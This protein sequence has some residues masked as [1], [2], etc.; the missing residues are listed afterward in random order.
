MAMANREINEV[1]I[2]GVTMI[3]TREDT[4]T[5]ETLLKGV[6]AHDASGEQIVGELD[7]VGQDDAYL[8][9]DEEGELADNDYLP[10]YDSSE[11]KKK[12]SLFSHLVDKLKSIFVTIS[13]N[14]VIEGQELSL[15]TE[16][17]ASKSDNGVEDIY[18]ATLSNILD[19][20]GRIIN[21]MG[22]EVTSDGKIETGWI[23][24][25][26]NTD[27]Q[28]IGLKGISFSMDKQGNLEYTIADEDAFREAIKT[29]DQIGT[30]IPNNSDLDNYK[31]AGTYAV[32]SDESAQT[33]SHIPVNVSGK[34]IVSNNG[35][36]GYTQFYVQNHEAKIFTRSFWNNAWSAWSE[37]GSGGGG[38]THT[39][40][41]GTAIPSNSDLDDYTE[42]GV[43]Y[44]NGITVAESLSNLPV[45]KAGKLVV[46]LMTEHIR[47]WQMYY[48]ADTAC[49]LYVRFMDNNS[50]WYSWIYIANSSNAYMLQSGV[51]TGF[52]S[53][54]DD[55]NNY[56][57]AGTYDCRFAS[58]ASS[59]SNCP[60]TDAFKMMV[61]VEGNSKILTQTITIIHNLSSMPWRRTK[62]NSNTW[63]EWKQF[64]AGA[65][66]YELGTDIPANSDLNN[67]TVAGTYRIGGDTIAS[68][69][70]NC[71]TTIGG[72]LL[73]L[74]QSY[75]SNLIIAIQIYIET[76]ANKIYK[77]RYNSAVTPNWNDWTSIASIDDI[78]PSTVGN[79]YA[80]ATISGS[81]ITATIDGF[82]LRAGVIVVLLLPSSITVN[83]TLNISNTGAKSIYM[84][85][86]SVISNGTYLPFGINTF[87]YDGTYYR[88][89][90]SNRSPYVDQ[91]NYV[92]DTSGSIIL[93]FGYGSNLVQIKNNLGLN[94]LRWNYYKNS[95]W[96]GDV[97]IADYDDI[98]HQTLGRD[99]L[100]NA[101]FN[102]YTT[103]GIYRVGTNARAQTIS[104]IAD[105]HAGKL[106]VMRVGGDGY[107]AQFYITYKADSHSTN[108]IYW[109]TRE[110]STWTQWL[111]FA[112]FDKADN[113]ISLLCN[114][115]TEDDKPVGI[116]AKILDTTTGKSFERQV[117]K[118]YQD[119]HATPYGLDMVMDS[120][121]NI[122][123]GSGESA[124]NL[125]PLVKDGAD[126][127]AYFLGDNQ[128]YFEA[129]ANTIANRLG[130]ELTTAHELLPVLAEVRT[131]NAGSIGNATYK[132]ANVYT[133]KI[134]GTDVSD[135][136]NVANS[137]IS[138]KS[139]STAITSLNDVPINTAGLLN[140][141]AATS[142]INLAGNYIYICYGKDNQ[143]T[144]EL[145]RMTH[146][147]KNTEERW[148][149]AYNGSSWTGW[150]PLSRTGTYIG[151]CTTAAGEQHKIATVDDD[152][153]L[154][155]GV[156][157]AIKYT[158]TNT[159]SVTASAHVTL[160]VNGTGDKEIW[161]WSGTNNTGT[162]TTFYGAAG[163]YIYYVYDGTYWV[164]DGHGGDNNSTYTPQSLGIGYGTN[165]EAATVIARAVTLSSYNLTTNGIIA[166][167]FTNAVPAGATLNVNGKG[168]KSIYYRGV[169]LKAN[170]I[171]AG[172]IATFI[173]SGQYH[174]LGI[175]RTTAYDDLITGTGTAA[176]D[177]G[178]GVTNRYVPAKWTF[179][180][181]RTATAGD[182]I[183]IKIPVAGHDYGVFVSVDN[184]SNYIPVALNGTGRLTTHFPINQTLQLVYEPDTT[185]N[186]VYPVA[187]G[188]ARV[189]ITGVWRVLNYR[190]SDTV[191]PC[192]LGFGYA[193]CA[194]AAATAAKVAT[195]SNY[196]LRTGGY[197]SVKFTNAVPAN[198]TLNINSRGAKNI[199]YRG[200]AIKADVIKAGDLATFIYSGQYHLVGID[201]TSYKTNTTS[202]SAVTPNTNIVIDSVNISTDGDMV[203][204]NIQYH[205]SQTLVAPYKLLSNLPM[206]YG[207][208][209]GVYC[210]GFTEYGFVQCNINSSGELNYL[211]SGR[212]TTDVTT[213]QFTYIKK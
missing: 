40:E 147:N 82:Q 17:D 18:E 212:I 167:K 3:S 56:T 205:A 84:R 183:T 193:T 105:E 19:K 134:N 120:A 89:L 23:V 170:V 176:Q 49:P 107:L 101:D 99:I 108:G 122:I 210:L 192:Y 10:F 110:N 133:N 115:T 166:V 96:R 142:P 27:G 31:T 124:T 145:T 119:H 38:G 50:V 149:N 53:A 188:D 57:T 93:G 7:P 184:G 80:V 199:Y 211:D 46:L 98:V 129:N 126:E 195:L 59:L 72:K 187:G 8:V 118:W 131:N 33:M 62:N 197:V 143:K 78:S 112:F 12:K 208:T 179:D 2:N 61:D 130:F 25:N 159:F 58:I 116:R 168:A 51:V 16:V 77:R 63:S 177:K 190:D 137:I 157:V 1:R 24:K 173:Y 178:S 85:N 106:I 182:I 165:T 135:I 70:S 148:Y 55:L 76:T 21:S 140:L 153:S 151:T 202:T 90:G 186:S 128:I 86:D 109:R 83:S 161:A 203:C 185:V 196:T 9:T 154:K 121:G 4:V 95:A 60:V 39:Y 35:D 206:P 14:T 181:G 136:T 102:D 48:V 194:T 207:G 67:Y 191:D 204:G 73:V 75:Q 171:K 113:M 42:A 163:R 88:H 144:I 92:A 125:Y 155:K 64:S 28:T 54:N 36:G 100:D 104:N 138:N 69:L 201:R 175:D 169:A 45:S 132:L 74:Y 41:E 13:G 29:I 103:N 20:E 164:W 37:I 6:T 87:M 34:L 198:A 200:A 97:N 22:V 114:T 146:G 11:G 79:G 209:T 32:I 174:L 65:H 141:D 52:I 111:S 5:K 139:Y 156:R 94:K 172:D 117:I 189:N 123:I 91:L 81:A 26:Y 30:A 15:K 162:Q 213:I 47:V 152:F 44:V 180:T 158:N 71:P 150:M 43:Y 127:V 68:S 66:T 160:N